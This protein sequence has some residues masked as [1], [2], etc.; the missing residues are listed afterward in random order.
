MSSV[1]QPARKMGRPLIPF[2]FFT[3]SIGSMHAL[4][5]DAVA[6]FSDVV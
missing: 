5:C 3:G 2:C 4:S 1:W 6:Q